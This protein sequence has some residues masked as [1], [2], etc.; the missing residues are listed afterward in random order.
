MLIKKDICII[1]YTTPNYYISK[2]FEESIERII[3]EQDI[4][5]K[6]EELPSDCFGEKDGFHHLQTSIDCG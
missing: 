4:F 3:N 6:K 1:A 2:Y 5:L